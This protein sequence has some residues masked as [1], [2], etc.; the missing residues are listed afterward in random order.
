[1]IFISWFASNQ[2]WANSIDFKLL[3]IGAYPHFMCAEPL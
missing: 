1:M 2:H 3:G